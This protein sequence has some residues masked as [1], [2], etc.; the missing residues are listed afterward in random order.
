MGT[1]GGTTWTRKWNPKDP[2][3]RTL[4]DGRKVAERALVHEP[5]S[6]RT[7]G[8]WALVD[9]ETGQVWNGEIMKS[10]SY[11]DLALAL[12]II[13]ARIDEARTLLDVDGLV[14]RAPP[15]NHAAIRVFMNAVG[16]QEWVRPDEMKKLGYPDAAGIPTMEAL[17]KLFN[18]E[19]ANFDDKYNRPGSRPE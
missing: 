5:L 9:M 3:Q 4:L 1:N 13:K 2:E 12:R 15:E 17:D 11:A 16:G 10:A 8:K 6:T 14:L 7:P 19:P 18:A